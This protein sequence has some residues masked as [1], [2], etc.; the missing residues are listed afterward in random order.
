MTGRR[1]VTRGQSWSMADE[2]KRAAGPIKRKADHETL[3][4]LEREQ[5]ELAKLC[6]PLFPPELLAEWHAAQLAWTIARAEKLSTAIAQNYASAPG[7]EDKGWWS[8]FWLLQARLR[9]LDWGQPHRFGARQ[10]L[11]LSG[12][13]MVCPNHGVDGVEASAWPEGP[14]GVDLREGLSLRGLLDGHG[15][16]TW[17]RYCESCG[18]TGPLKVEG[19]TLMRAW[20]GR[21]A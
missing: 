17:T 12:H 1:V 15:A 7:P 9:N 3:T 10:L 2:E 16:M 4:G 21:G 20:L 18:M 5:L 8:K 11:E 6:A 14:E 13:V 19:A